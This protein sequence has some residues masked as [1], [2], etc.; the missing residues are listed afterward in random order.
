MLRTRTPTGSEKWEELIIQVWR[1]GNES[2]LFLKQ[3][4]QDDAFAILAHLPKSFSVPVSK[5]TFP[6]NWARVL[7]Q[8]ENFPI[9]DD[10]KIEDYIDRTLSLKPYFNFKSIDDYKKNLE[11]VDY[12]RTALVKD[13]ED[14]YES[15][16]HD[17]QIFQIRP[18]FYSVFKTDDLEFKEILNQFELEEW[19]MAIINS[20]RDY[21]KKINSNLDDKKRYLFSNYLKQLDENNLDLLLQSEIREKI[22]KTFHQFKLHQ[23]LDNVKNLDPKKNEESEDAK[24]A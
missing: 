15:L 12:L 13:E 3:I 16:P 17:S 19:A 22:G 4:P 18:P 7:E 1:L 23:K 20:P 21:I 2:H 6:G 9:D 10:A 5:R 24:A 14:I 8:K 11:L